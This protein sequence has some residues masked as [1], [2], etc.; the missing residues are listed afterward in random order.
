MSTS[1]RSAATNRSRCWTGPGY[2]KHALRPGLTVERA[3]AIIFC[4]VSH[5][6]YLSF[7]AARGWTG[8]EWEQW[9]NRT[10]AATIPR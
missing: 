3:T 4:L 9:I 2:D 5:E 10:L 7:T 1:W 8:G 6:L